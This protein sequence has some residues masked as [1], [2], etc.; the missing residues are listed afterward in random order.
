MTTHLTPAERVKFLRQEFAQ[1]DVNHDSNLTKEEL[2]RALDEM[3]D[4]KIF[5][6]DV[7]YQLYER[8]DQNH[9]GTVT[10]DEFV[11][12]FIEAEDILKQKIEN[13]DAYLADF[14]K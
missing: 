13:A 4:G 8:M 3:N 9:D 12:V 10:V 14:Q 11:K 7:A 5:D 2:C 1:V 6:R